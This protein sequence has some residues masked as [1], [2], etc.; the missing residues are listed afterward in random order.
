[1][2]D[3]DG[4]IQIICTYIQYTDQPRPI[5]YFL[6]QQEIDFF[7]RYEKNPFEMTQKQSEWMQRCSERLKE[8]VTTVTYEWTKIQGFTVKERKT[9]EWSKNAAA[10][11]K[12][13]WWLP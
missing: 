13:K 8:Y 7:K 6:T 11:V 10:R 2:L 5:P 12:N 4:F 9:Q 1:M 3:I